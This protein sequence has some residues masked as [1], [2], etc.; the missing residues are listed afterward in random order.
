MARRRTQKT[1]SSPRR[2]NATIKKSTSTIFFLVFLNFKFEFKFFLLKQKERHSKLLN[3]NY[4]NNSP[5]INSTSNGINH[6]LDS[7]NSLTSQDPSS[8]SNHHHHHHQTSKVNLVDKINILTQEFKMKKLNSQ[9]NYANGYDDDDDDEDDGDEV[10]G[11]Y[12]KKE[13]D[14][15]RASSVA[16]SLEH[17]QALQLPNFKSTLL[18]ECLND[19][20]LNESDLIELIRRQIKQKNF[21]LESF[22]DNYDELNDVFD[23]GD[24]GKNENGFG[25]EL[26]YFNGRVEGCEDE[27]GDDEIDYGQNQISPQNNRL[28]T[29]LEVS[30]EESPF[31]K[32]SALK[33]YNAKQ[34]QKKE[35]LE[36]ETSSHESN[37]TETATNGAGAVASSFAKLD[38]KEQALND[39]NDDESDDGDKD[40]VEKQ[41]LDI[42]SLPIGLKPTNKMSFEQLIEEKLKIAEQLDHE[43]FKNSE[44]NKNK[45]KTVAMSK[46]REK[47][48][49]AKAA[50][51]KENNKQVQ[52]TVATQQSSTSVVPNKVTPKSDAIMQAD[53]GASMNS[54]SDSG[55]GAQSTSLKQPCKFL[56]R[57]EGLKRYQPPSVKTNQKA[58]VSI[59]S[60]LFGLFFFLENS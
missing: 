24:D 28:S 60:L 2:S 30:C 51:S 8:S 34:Q 32:L 19:T 21:K 16:F 27:C 26:N 33:E 54:E 37:K 23:D 18:D 41:P 44:S 55:V 25:K 57:G 42:D 17:P 15:G 5:L 11:A 56:K 58:S 1:I 38:D 45:K 31:K 36:E 49:Q 53:K 35:K 12:S 46:T 6:M 7:N 50:A 47:F 43:Q 48:I 39:K 10:N 14:S 20:S 29:I 4:S 13:N 9:Y 40:E 52:Q 22:I 3:N 59:Y